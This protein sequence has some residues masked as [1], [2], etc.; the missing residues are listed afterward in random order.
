MFPIEVEDLTKVYGTRAVVDRVTFSVPQGHVF[1]LL[2]PNGSGKTTIIKLLT[3]LIRPSGGRVRVMGNDLARHPL[4]AKA[5]LGHVYSGMAFYS[6]LSALENLTFFG[7]LY[8]LKRSVLRQRL[9]ETLEFVG[10]WDERK[11]RVGA[12]SQGM[13]QRLGIA[14]A[15][16][17]DPRVLLLD[18]ATSG[19]DV[20]GVNAIRELVYHLRT[21]DK[22]ILIASHQ[23][24]E[25]ELLSDSI[26]LL[27]AG[28]LISVGTPEGIKASLRGI[29]RKYVVRVPRPL[30]DFGV[31]VANHWF[32]KDSNI[33]IA[34]EDIGSAL[35]ERFGA[36]AV[37]TVDAT[38]EEVFLWML[39]DAQPH[40][41]TTPSRGSR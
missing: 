36:Q 8:R 21:L 41:E 14:R 40:R 18:E 13:K 33:V 37:Q 6:H 30:D 39:G 9:V 10:L 38:L 12:Y 7:R 24:G 3:G 1:G 25:I 15:I 19:I 20:Q 4:Q 23:L 5:A 26:G 27:K 22:T 31:A 17:H 32:V 11:K 16:L 28:R 29:L 35:V 2:G 34:G